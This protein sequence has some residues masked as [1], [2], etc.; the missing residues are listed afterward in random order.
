MRCHR[1]LAA[2]MAVAL[3]AG[4][5]STQ[6]EAAPVAPVEEAAATQPEPVRRG[7]PAPGRWVVP[8]QSDG[9]AAWV[10]EYDGT[11]TLRVHQQPGAPTGEVDVKIFAR[12]DTLHGVVL[13]TRVAHQNR[14]G[15]FFRGRLEHPR[16]LIG[17]YE[18]APGD[19]YSRHEVTVRRNGTTLAGEARAYTTRGGPPHSILTFEVKRRESLVPAWD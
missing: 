13:M 3:A 15:F 19:S 9:P 12:G 6:P 16:Q 5:A 11:G 4:C 2:G 17:E 1:S 8:G 14:S 18:G 10:G 7:P